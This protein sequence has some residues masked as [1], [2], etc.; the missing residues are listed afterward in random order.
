MYNY[1]V[2]NQYRTV[3]VESKVS[4]STPHSLVAMLLDGVLQRLAM[5]SG[6]IQR[7]SLPEQGQALSAGIRIID[8]LRAS[9][10][11]DSGGELAD[12]LG[13]IYDYIER[14]LVEANTKSDVKIIDE[15]V[16]LINQI[17]SGWDAIPGEMRGA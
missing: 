3:D 15:V 10:D 14:R 8:A 17:K 13:A 4:S 7:G 5:A 9:L 1:S 11:H 16:S 2:L 6:A 12:N